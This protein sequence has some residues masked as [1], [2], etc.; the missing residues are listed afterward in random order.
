MSKVAIPDPTFRL[1]PTRFPPVQALEGLASPAD[2]EL[3][4]EL[5]GWTNDRLV[6]QRLRRLPR[7]RWVYAAPNASVVMAAFLHGSPH[8]GRFNG[9]DLGAWY[10]SLAETTAIVEVAHHLRREVCRAGMPSITGEYRCYTAELA[11]A[12]LDLRGDRASRPELYARRD[13]GASQRFGE[14][15]R[16]AGD[17][18]IVYDSVR[19]QGGTNVVAYDPRNVRA[20][21]AASVFAVTAHAG[22]PRPDIRRLS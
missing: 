17:D 2:L 7:E 3:N 14:A 20:V 12:Y 13:Y 5:E 10:C 6:V 8:G 4:L 9:P 18:G 11:G 22:S 16:A 19:H 15:R 1:I 21:V